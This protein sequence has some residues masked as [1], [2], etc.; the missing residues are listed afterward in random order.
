MRQPSSKYMKKEEVGEI[1]WK[2]KK[3][4]LLRSNKV[5]HKHGIL[6]VRFEEKKNDII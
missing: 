1:I 6:V 3:C 5:T 2:C 4:G